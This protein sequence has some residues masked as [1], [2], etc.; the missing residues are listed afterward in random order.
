MF[1]HVVQ[2]LILYL[3]DLFTAT[4]PSPMMVPGWQTGLPYG[5]GFNMQYNTAAVPIV[6][7]DYDFLGARLIFLTC[8]TA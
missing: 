7:H 3:Q 4:Y 8:L 6:Q 2:R 1:S 5:Y